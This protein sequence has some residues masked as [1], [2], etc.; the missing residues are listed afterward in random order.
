MFYAGD[1]SFYCIRTTVYVTSFR[2][3]VILLLVC[4]TC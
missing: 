4:H 2:V 3:R 1:G